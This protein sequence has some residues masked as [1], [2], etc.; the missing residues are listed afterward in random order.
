MHYVLQ[1]TIDIYILQT[2]SYKANAI[3]SVTNSMNGLKSICIIFDPP[4]VNK[5]LKHGNTA[6]S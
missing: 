4:R 5:A 1:G 3:L 2:W 6:V